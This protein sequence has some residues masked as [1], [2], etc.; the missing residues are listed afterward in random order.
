MDEKLKAELVKAIET[1]ELRTGRKFDPA[2]VYDVLKYS[3]N[4]LSYIGKDMDY[5][6]LLFENELRDHIMREKIN[7]RGAMSDVLN[8]RPCTVSQQVS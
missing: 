4:K 5:L 8:L 6:P 3:I 7:R 2:V 1:A